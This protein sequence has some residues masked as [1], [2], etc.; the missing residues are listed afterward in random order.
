MTVFSGSDSYEGIRIDVRFRWDHE[1]PPSARWQQPFSADGG[2]TWELNW[3][4]EFGRRSDE[5]DR[6]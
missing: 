6:S 2:G 5:L 1:G 3:V 4:M